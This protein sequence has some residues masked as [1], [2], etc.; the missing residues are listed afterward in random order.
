MGELVKQGGEQA[1]YA[2]SLGSDGL[3]GPHRSPRYS[4]RP[5]IPRRSSSCSSG[6]LAKAE[7]VS[8]RQ[9]QTWKSCAARKTP[10]APIAVQAHIA[11]QAMN[12]GSASERTVTKAD[13]RHQQRTLH[14]SHM[15]RG[16]SKGR[17]PWLRCRLVHPSV[18]SEPV[19]GISPS[20]PEACHAA[21]PPLLL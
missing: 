8:E 19:P 1:E 18:P 17:G 2:A 10:R 14:L 13:D 7:R 3:M 6:L 5:E 11:F 4:S 9:L 21:P 20:C 16:A 15:P 12:S